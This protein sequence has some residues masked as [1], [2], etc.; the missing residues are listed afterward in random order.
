MAKQKYGNKMKVVDGETFS[1]ILE[2][3]RYRELVIM[4]RS[5]AITDLKTQVAY[6]LCPSVVIAGRKRRSM[7]YIADFVYKDDEGKTVVED[8]KG[9]LTPVYKRKRHLMMHVHGIKINEIFQR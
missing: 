9:V 5:G 2:A 6:V 4:Q 8:A 3:R 7:S 1:S